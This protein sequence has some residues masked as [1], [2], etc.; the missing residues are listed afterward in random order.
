MEIR[1]RGTHGVQT[2]GRMYMEALDSMA[3]KWE[4]MKEYKQIEKKGTMHGVGYKR[5]LHAQEHE[6]EHAN[7]QSRSTC[8]ESMWCVTQLARICRWVHA[9]WTYHD[10]V[11]K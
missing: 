9:L 1:G 5:S 11:L 4:K 2:L 8:V 10:G 7:G 3:T 6:H